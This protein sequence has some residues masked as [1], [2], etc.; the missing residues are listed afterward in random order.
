MKGETFV[1]GFT[2]ILVQ[3]KIIKPDEAKSLK[4]AFKESSK[5]NFDEFLIDEGLVEKDAVLAALSQYYHVPAFDAVGYFFD[6]QLVRMFPKVFLRS[7]AIIPIERDENI[8]VVLAS[9]PNDQNLL[10]LIGQYVSYD[11]QFRVGIQQDIYDAIQEFYDQSL[12]SVDYD[13]DLDESRQ[14]REEDIEQQQEIEEL[15][16]KDFEEE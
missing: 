14:E 1:E 5:A 2:K 12:A 11:I 16:Y 10:P 6:H 4:K 3:H 15:A 7:N 9:N 8:L 13:Q